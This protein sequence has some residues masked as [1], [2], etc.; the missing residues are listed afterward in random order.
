MIRL[1]GRRFAGENNANRTIAMQ[2]PFIAKAFPEVAQCH[3]GTINLELVSPLIVACS[4]HRTPPI[5]WKPNLTE[6]EIFDLV[7]V[8]LEVPFDGP[9]HQAWLYVAHRSRHRTDLRRHEVIAPFIELAGIEE[10]GL[11]IEQRSIELPYKHNSL[12]VLT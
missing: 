6:G 9:R 4:D 3:S 5:K 7:R 2:L 11:V 12:Y 1:R 8:F 10:Y